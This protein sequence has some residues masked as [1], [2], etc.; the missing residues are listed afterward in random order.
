MIKINLPCKHVQGVVVV[1]NGGDIT[2]ERNGEIVT[3][4]DKG[5]II[6]SNCPNY[7]NCQHSK[8]PFSC[9]AFSDY[10]RYF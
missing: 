7:S 6:D 1:T 3:V 4:T 8:S 9:D 5:R 10:P 2:T